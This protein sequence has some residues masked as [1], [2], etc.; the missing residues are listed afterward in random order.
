MGVTG[1]DKDIS[2]NVCQ[3]IVKINDVFS[4]VIPRR[5]ISNIISAKIETFSFKKMPLKL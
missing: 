5:M 3:A 1:L 4:E 2:F